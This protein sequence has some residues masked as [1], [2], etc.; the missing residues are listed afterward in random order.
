MSNQGPAEIAAQDLG[1][2]ATD[3]LAPRFHYYRVFLDG[4][5]VNDLC[6]ETFYGSGKQ[7]SGHEIPEKGVNFYLLKDVPHGEIRER[8]YHA[9]ATQLWRRVFVYTPPGY[10]ADRDQLGRA[11]RSAGQPRRG[12]RSLSRIVCRSRLRLTDLPHCTT[13][14]SPDRLLPGTAGG[15]RERPQSAPCVRSCSGRFW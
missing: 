14:N 15:A 8:W 6:S 13:H 7:T 1:K 11:A 3:P 5:D 2:K 9:K 4:V 12:G 10:E